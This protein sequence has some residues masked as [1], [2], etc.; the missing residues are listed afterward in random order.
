MRGHGQKNNLHKTNL[1]MGKW[2]LLGIS[3]GVLQIIS[4]QVEKNKQV[5][6]DRH[7]DIQNVNSRNQE[8]D[9]KSVF[10]L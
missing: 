9:L 1:N 4:L 7:M 8:N 10:F 3:W 6:N 5:Q 2:F